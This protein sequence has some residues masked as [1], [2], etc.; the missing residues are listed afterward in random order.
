MM[1]R[2]GDT[3]NPIKLSEADLKL[4]TYLSEIYNCVTM[5]DII[6]TAL[7]KVK[8]NKLKRMCDRHGIDYKVHVSQK[9]H[10]EA[11][12][13]AKLHTILQ[14]SS[15]K[16]KTLIRY[17]IDNLHAIV[18]TLYTT[19]LTDTTYK[20]IEICTRFM[21]IPHT[22]KN[23]NMFQRALELCISTNRP[24]A[25]YDILVTQGYQTY[26]DFL[27]GL[28]NIDMVILASTAV[29]LDCK[30]IIDIMTCELART[31][32][33]EDDHTF[34]QKYKIERQFQSEIQTEY[35]R[36]KSIVNGIEH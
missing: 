12:L 9:N 6:Q 27:R 23:P 16:D 15:G 31:I 32:K 25:I 28:Q 34:R 35:A 2:V 36:F 7:P 4:S 11:Q 20:Y 3:H 26:V 18:S 19:E 1:V 10:F 21:A 17:Y 5:E 33:Y 8:K 30:P 13:S 14:E 22:H 29:R 24:E